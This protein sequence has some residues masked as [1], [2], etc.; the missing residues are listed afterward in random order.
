MGDTTQV[1]QYMKQTGK[2]NTAVYT[3]EFTIILPFKKEKLVTCMAVVLAAK[4]SMRLTFR[5]HHKQ[6][7]KT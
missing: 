1:G 5:R 7:I 3:Y 6:T 2:E 4:T